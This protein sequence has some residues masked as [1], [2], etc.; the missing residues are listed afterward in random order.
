MEECRIMRKV[1][2]FQF[3]PRVLLF[4]ALGLMLVSALVALNTGS[5]TAAPVQATTTAGATGTG[6]SARPAGTTGTAVSPR[7][8]G[9]PE[10]PRPA[11]GTPATT[12]TAVASVTGTAGPPTGFNV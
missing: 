12:G 9:T 2:G 8:T 7:T 1:T 3:V 10:T 4:G 5:S 6:G 11:V